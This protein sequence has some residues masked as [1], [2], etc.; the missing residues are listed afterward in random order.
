MSEEKNPNTAQ[1]QGKQ[2]AQSQGTNRRAVLA[3]TALTATGLA[4]AGVLAGCST[5][6]KQEES[7]QNQ[8]A[9]DTHPF[10]GEHQS[11]ITT[12]V[13]DRMYFVAL[14]L[15]ISSKEEIKQLFKDWTAASRKLM[16]GEIVGEDTSYEA[17]PQDTGEAMDLSAAHLTL[18]FGLGRSFFV[19]ANDKDRFGL[20]INCLRRWWISLKC[21]G[22]P[23]KI[24]V[25]GVICAFRH[26]P[27]T[28]RWLFTLS[29]TW[30]ALPP[31][32]PWSPG[33]SWGLDAHLQ[34]PPRR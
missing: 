6:Q 19:D 3:G 8:G 10:F 31:G 20:K 17:P 12:E 9:K 7:N 29:A 32:G 30:C 1:Q 26:A 2:P 13:Q 21:L 22:M 15:K 24:T 11:G 16:A 4:A 33:A 27:M 25:A 28:R 14:T 5:N 23:S 34:P 18:T